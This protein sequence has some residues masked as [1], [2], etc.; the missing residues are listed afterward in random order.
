MYL[1]IIVGD[2]GYRFIAA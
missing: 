1:V 2:V